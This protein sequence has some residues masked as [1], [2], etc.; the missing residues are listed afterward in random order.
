[1]PT[2]SDAP[3]KKGPARSYSRQHS[4][5]PADASFVSNGTV[6]WTNDDPDV[7]LIE[8]R[9]MVS[10]NVNWIRF[11]LKEKEPEHRRFTIIN[12]GDTP[13]AF[14][15]RCSDNYAYYFNKVYGLIPGRRMN[16]LPDSRD[17]SCFT[18]A[19]WRRP[20][21]AFDIREV[22]GRHKDLVEIHLAPAYSF[23]IPPE[24]LFHREA[25][26]E[27]LRICFEYTAEAKSGEAETH[28]L[29]RPDM[30]YWNTWGERGSVASD[31]EEPPS[32][33]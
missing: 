30:K 29:L 27:Q 32:D 13:V 24:S 23:S 9:L 3:A 18:V 6:L 14:K 4:T 20:N 5:L 19:V 21:D 26:Y 12:H 15:L 7:R 8:P 16:A 10:I 17:V 1:M 22:E 2:H 31:D 28:C 11:P 33:I 25:A